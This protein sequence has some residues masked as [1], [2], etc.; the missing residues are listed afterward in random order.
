MSGRGGRF[1]SDI[2]GG[3]DKPGGTAGK[4]GGADGTDGTGADNGNESVDCEVGETKGA[5]CEL[6]SDSAAIDGA[7]EATGCGGGSL[8]A[9]GGL[10]STGVAG[11]F[12]A[13]V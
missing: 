13:G 4:P 5:S 2:P 9:R 6:L 1:S 12:A 7:G 3:A 8:V 11:G 10:T